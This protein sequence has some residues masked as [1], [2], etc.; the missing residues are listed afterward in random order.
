M[1]EVNIKATFS[2]SI[3]TIMQKRT[4]ITDDCAT[5]TTVANFAAL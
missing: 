5:D 4:P 3:I 1:L 2:R